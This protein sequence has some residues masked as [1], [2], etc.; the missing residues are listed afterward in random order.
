MD[1]LKQI[2]IILFWI[3]LSETENNKFIK[4]ELKYNPEKD[5]NVE[6]INKIFEDIRNESDKN[7]KNEKI[8]VVFNGTKLD[9][10]FEK[11]INDF[12]VV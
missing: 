1:R 7:Y 10:N 2:S 3:Y 4:D 5:Y 12:I 6:K 11:Y 9:V 8:S